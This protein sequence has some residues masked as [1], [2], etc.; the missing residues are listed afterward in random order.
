MEIE[1]NL[2]SV[3]D[4]LLQDFGVVL[5]LY[6]QCKHPRSQSNV[7]HSVFV[8][9]TASQARPGVIYGNKATYMATCT[10]PMMPELR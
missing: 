8:M 2:S 6:D 5:R 3:F 4:V 9:A 7:K 10:M 1:A